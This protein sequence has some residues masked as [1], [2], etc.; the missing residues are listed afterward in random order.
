M[1]FVL[2]VKEENREGGEWGREGMEIIQG[3]RSFPPFEMTVK[4][5]K[6]EKKIGRRKGH[7]TS[8]LIPTTHCILKREIKERKYE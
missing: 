5:E 4:C 6:E 2:I 7:D 8:S 1:V 3:F